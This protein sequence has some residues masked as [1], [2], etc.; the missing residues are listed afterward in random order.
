MQTFEM[1]LNNY[2]LRLVNIGNSWETT[3]LFNFGKD[4]LECDLLTK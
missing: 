3:A 1:S 4:G 2:F